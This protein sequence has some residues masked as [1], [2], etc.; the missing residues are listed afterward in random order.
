MRGFVALPEN[1][2]RSC[3]VYC[4]L[5]PLSVCSYELNEP[6]LARCTFKMLREFLVEIAKDLKDFAYGVTRWFL[7]QGAQLLF[8]SLH[9]L[10]QFLL[11]LRKPVHI[12]L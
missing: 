5:E 9:D 4:A 2:F 12:V 6:T 3:G 7:W 11:N 10:V 1:K 8:H